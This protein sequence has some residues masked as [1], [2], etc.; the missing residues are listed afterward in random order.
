MEGETDDAHENPWAQLGG[1]VR[2]WNYQWF[3]G[4]VKSKFTTKIK[5]GAI[6]TL[7]TVFGTKVTCTGETSTGEYT[8][9]L[10]SRTLSSDSRVA[11]RKSIVKPKGKVTAT[12]QPSR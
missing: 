4:V 7:E 8:D 1:R 3:S 12:S 10:K 5:A 11:N 6:V 9:P 2:A